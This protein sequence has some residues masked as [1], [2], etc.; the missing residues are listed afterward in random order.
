MS[1]DSHI[2]RL[3]IL[4]IAGLLFWAFL[5]GHL[6]RIQVWRGAEYAD[7]AR[8]QHERR[9]ALEAMRGRLLDRN[10]EE[11]AINL[12]SSSFAANPARVGEPG[13]I[14]RQISTLTGRSPRV[15]LRALQKPGS[16][17]WLV[18]KTEPDVAQ[19]IRAWDHP[20]LWEII[21]T[22]RW[23]PFGALA[24]QAI[25]FTDLDNRGIEGAELSF[26]DRL[27]GRP[28]WHTVSVDGRGYVLANSISPDCV[29]EHGDNVVL[30]IDARYQQILEEELD[31]AVRNFKARSGMGVLMHPKT[32]EILAMANVPLCD[33]NRFWVYKT[34]LRKNRTITDVYEPGSV[35]KIVTAA[36]VIEEG[37]MDS[38]TVVFCENGRMKVAG[39]VIRDA[40]EY[41]SLTFREVVEHSS[42]IG[43]IKAARRA[44]DGAIYTYARLFGFGAKTGVG[45]RGEVSGVLRH[46]SSWSRRS[47]DT[48]AMGHEVS[49][50]ALQLAAAYSAVANGGL[51]MRP[52]ILQSVLRPEGTLVYRSEREIVRRVISEETARVLVDFLVGV[53]QNGTGVNAHIEGVEIGA[54]TGT[55]QRV[56]EH[57]RGYSDDFISTFVGF[58]P[59]RDPELVCVVVLDSPKGAHFSS[60]VAAPTFRRIMHR[61]LNLKDPPVRF[62]REATVAG[63][64]RASV[65]YSSSVETG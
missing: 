51:L 56:R 23:Y 13:I 37:V 3:R 61:I 62:Y 49:V 54:K 11:L 6:F 59:A 65:P 43:T 40:H 38:N 2:P 64:P 9:K 17:V 53:V 58:L 45:L 20:G 7:D 48:I 1:N 28:G 39:G 22:V 63:I 12:R 32:G 18:R 46:P 5:A 8:G 21:E 14:S 52:R 27:D 57:G 30:T 31:Q 26:N 60:Q 15:L 10:G 19:T 34:G 50:T 25:G 16:F 29:P 47:L 24:G 42:N 36:A 35:F 41:G 33:P 4:V 44:G 55:A